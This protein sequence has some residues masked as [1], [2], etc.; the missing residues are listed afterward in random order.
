MK[1]STDNVTE[2]VTQSV[3]TDPITRLA[4]KDR[5][6]L[7]HGPVFTLKLG[8]T[9]IREEIPKRAAMAMSTVLNDALVK[10]PRSSIIKLNPAGLDERS[11][12]ILID[13]INGNSKTNKPFS[14]RVSETLRELV[15]L[16]RHACMLGMDHNA[17]GLRHKILEHVNGN[18]SVSFSA[19]DE[20][21]QLPVTD[22]CWRTAV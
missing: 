11:V 13:F 12:R 20:I 17:G 6:E 14:I 10:H 19:L 9:T 8:D 5:L 22:S 3:I 4:S 1:A 15:N 16:Y 7:G 2:P 21:A 18:F